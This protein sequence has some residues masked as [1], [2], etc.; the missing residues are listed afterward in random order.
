MDDCAVINASPLILLSRSGHIQLLS[1]FAREILIPDQVAAEI[2]VRGPDDPTVRVMDTNKWLKVVDVHAV[3]ASILEWRLGEGEAAVIALAHS[4]PLAVAVI[5]DLL[6]RRCALAHGIPVRGSIG[7]VI[8]AREKG[9]I[10]E[11]RPV[12]DD[13][14]KA[15]LYL[16]RRVLDRVLQLA[17][18]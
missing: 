15:G 18:E 1:H 14:I 10:P 9:F 17:G 16:S 4:T 12:I 5:D 8:A 11:A 3:P 6:G 7:I 2:R 13:L